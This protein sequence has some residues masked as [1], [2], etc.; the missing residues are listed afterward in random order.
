MRTPP[1][2][3]QQ[4]MH[5][6]PEYVPAQGRLQRAYAGSHLGSRLFPVD[7]GEDHA[8][9]AELEGL[10]KGTLGLVVVHGVHLQHVG[11]RVLLHVCQVVLVGAAAEVLAVLAFLEF[12]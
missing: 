9:A 2:V 1:P 12:G 6:F 3:G 7:D 8:A 11:G 10:D 5:V 4:D